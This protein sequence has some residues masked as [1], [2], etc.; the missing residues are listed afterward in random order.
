MELARVHR[1]RTIIED[2]ARFGCLCAAAAL[3]F[4]SDVPFWM[5]LAVVGIIQLAPIVMA[6]RALEQGWSRRWGPRVHQ[7]NGTKSFV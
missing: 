7:F 2:P 3:L 4:V 1:H 5:T 6:A